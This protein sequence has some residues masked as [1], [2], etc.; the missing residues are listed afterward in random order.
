MKNMKEISHCYWDWH[1][2][3]QN[4]DYWSA[5]ASKFEDYLN[6]LLHKKP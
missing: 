6:P 3:H 2:F 1:V 5:N 4:K